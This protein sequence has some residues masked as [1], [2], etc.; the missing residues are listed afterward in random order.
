MIDQVYKGKSVIQCNI[1][2]KLQDY[3]EIS[4]FIA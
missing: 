4:L 2:E 1:L 3:L